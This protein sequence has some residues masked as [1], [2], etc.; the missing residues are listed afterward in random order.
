[1]KSVRPAA[2]PSVF[3]L[4]LPLL[5]A[6]CASLSKDECLS[7][8]WRTIGYGD[9]SEGFARTRIS[10]HRQACA[11]YSVT[12]DLDA[13]NRG[14]E[15][16]LRVYCTARKGYQQGVNGYTY[17]G[18]CPAG[19]EE[20]F[21]EAYAFGKDIYAVRSGIKARRHERNRA[22]EQLQAIEDEIAH[23]EAA[24]IKGHMPPHQRALLLEDLKRLSEDKQA[25]ERLIYDLDNIIRDLRHQLAEM[26]ANNPFE[27]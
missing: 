23:T 24:L 17:R 11:Q 1:M 10:E 27:R 19:L 2:L 6:G 7:A 5:L 13:Y 14:Y 25:T 9:A 20:P 18:I 3:L 12:P 15:Q 22:I 4:F 8:D 21:L 16:G 26:M